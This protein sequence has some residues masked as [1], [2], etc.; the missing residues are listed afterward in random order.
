MVPVG[1]A[2]GPSPHFS[3]LDR[4]FLLVT[5]LPGQLLTGNIAYSPGQWY[6][7]EG[8]LGDPRPF[9]ASYC[10]FS[11][12]IASQPRHTL[13]GETEIFP[14]EDSRRSL[15][16]LVFLPALSGTAHASASRKL[17]LW[18]CCSDLHSHGNFSRVLPYV[19]A[20]CQLWS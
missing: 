9:L 17:S 16:E 4:A 6:P 2:H 5:K 8:A 1:G 19:L 15:G 12:F 20:V 13:L 14:Q 11:C 10:C 18:F 3:C 7:D